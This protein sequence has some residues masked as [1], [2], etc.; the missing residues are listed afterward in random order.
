MIRK[1]IL[2]AFTVSLSGAASAASERTF[3]VS[4]H[5][6]FKQ[7]VHEGDT[8]GKVALAPY[9]RAAGTYGVGALAGL[10]GEILIWDGSVFVTLG[11]SASGST[12]RPRADDQAT[13]LVTAW[14]KEWG[15][16]QMAID[17]TQQEFERFVIDSARSMGIDINKPF[18]FI[19]IGEV[20]NYTWHVVTGT[21]KHPGGGAQHQQGHASDRAFSGAKTEGKLVGFFSAE[22][23][24]GVLSHP[25]E[26]FHVHYADNDIKTSGHLDGFGVAKGA[27][28]LL[29]K[30]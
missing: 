22:E 7:M 14:V 19:V 4:V 20:T 30:Q 15:E 6:N 27:R 24:E 28:L 29:P 11:E 25:G 26:R 13:F 2:I 1:A 9:V 23:L 18:P 5:G 16:R 8:S 3:N 17:M 12:Q 10:R 21:S